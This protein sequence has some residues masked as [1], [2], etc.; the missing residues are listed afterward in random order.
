M[1]ILKIKSVPMRTVEN[2]AKN[3]CY[4]NRELR[5]GVLF[6]KMYKILMKYSDESSEEQDEVFDT[7]AEA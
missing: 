2:A 6:M 3:W 4:E 5:K 1:S 7:E